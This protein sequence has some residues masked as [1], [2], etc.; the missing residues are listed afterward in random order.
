MGVIVHFTASH[1]I[2]ENILLLLLLLHQYPLVLNSLTPNFISSVDLFS[3]HLY[4]E[5]QT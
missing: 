2:A 3:I 4:T 5:P 1:L